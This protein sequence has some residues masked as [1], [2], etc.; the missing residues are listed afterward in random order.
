MNAN[1]ECLIKRKLAVVVVT[2]LALLGAAPATRAQQPE[3]ADRTLAPYFFVKSEDPTVDRLPLKSTSA[4]VR[5][6]GVIADVTVTQVYRN[7]GKRTLEAIYVFPGSTRAAVY[8]MTMKIGTRTIEAVI[9]ERQQA[10]A[11]YEQARSQGRTASLL[12]QQRPNVFQMNV[13]NILPRDEVRVTLRYTELLVPTEGVYEFVYPTVVG[14]RYSNRP[15]AGAADTERWVENPNHHQGEAPS[16]TFDIKATLSAGMPIQ[17]VT[18]PSH[19]T[20]VAFDGTSVASV[21]LD[22]SETGGGNRDFVLRYALA[23]SAVQTGLLLWEGKDE[24]FFLLMAQP[25]A[26]VAAEQIP[27]RDYV[28]I[29]DVSGSM[30]GYP[31]EVSKKLLADLI[32][33]LRPTDSFNV[34]L[35]S[36]GSAA[37]AERPLPATPENIRRAIDLIEKQQ[38]G[39]GTELIPALRHALALPRPEGASRTVVIATDGYVDVEKDA[40]EL[41][42]NS[43]DRSNVFAFGI[44]TAVNRFLI[45]GIARAGM[46][47]PFVVTKPEEAE[48]RAERFRRYV[49]SPVL[50]Q[51]RVD[52]DA[53]GAYDVEPP[54][55]PD[56]LAERPVIVFGK[57]RGKPSGHVTVHGE[58]G[59]GPY[60]RAID[61]SRVKPM[62]ANSA[63]RYLWARH[64]VAALGDYN[65][66][67]RDGD[68]A[69]EITRLGLAYNLLTEFTS[70]VAVDT[71][72]RASDG[73]VETITL[74]LPLPQGVS[75]LAV[76]GPAKMAMY[77]PVRGSGGAIGGVMGGVPGGVPGGVAYSA[78]P[79]AEQI[80]IPGNSAAT[81]TSRRSAANPAS[82]L[83][84]EEKAKDE[85]RTVWSG[86]RHTVRGWRFPASSGASTVTVTLR[87]INGVPSV[88]GVVSAGSLSSVDAERV[89]KTALAQRSSAL[90]RAVPAGMELVMTIN[91]RPDGT[92]DS[93]EFAAN[94]A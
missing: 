90:E 32:G 89:V 75:D 63:L 76:G 15:A 9:K 8:G 12:E 7:E 85:F 30:H 62:E 11:D 79:V 17:R 71:V 65:A 77:A 94:H 82:N 23:G 31:L 72:V 18:C 68:T 93:V 39:G 73:K 91:V 36:G 69:K 87:R 45:E 20:S 24:N 61:V 47:E 64:R 16:Y 80:A 42:R 56:V 50:T 84:K 38:G 88:V 74:P 66:L 14:P 27:P 21:T 33:H 51:V 3:S 10:R 58:T 28:F 25:P 81:D 70:F 5:I 34:L 46:G 52:L 83:D 19:R 92:V 55:V 4:D 67:C 49:Q 59:G 53:L 41:I 6:A 48:A 1:T 22:P 86:L 54:T 2:A 29:M 37:M 40:F 78:P 43:L 13:A 26:R 35:F 60:S 57:W 44:G